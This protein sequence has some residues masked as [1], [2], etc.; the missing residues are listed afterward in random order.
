MINKKTS[1]DLKKIYNEETY[2]KGKENFHTFD[3][4][5]IYETIYKFIGKDN[6]IVSGKSVLDLGCG[7]GSF[8]CNYL[9]SA[10]FIRGIDFSEEAIKKAKQNSYIPIVRFDCISFE[11]YLKIKIIEPVDVV[12]SLD[13]IEHCVNPEIIF[14]VAQ[15]ALMPNGVLIIDHPCF[16][17][18]RGALWKALE[19]FMEAEMTCTDLHTLFF[20]DIYDMTKKYGFE[21]QEWKT[22]R[23]NQANGENLLYDFNKRLR[24]AIGPLLN[25]ENDPKINHFIKY[26]KIMVEN[27][28]FPNN[29]KNGAQLLYK[30]IKK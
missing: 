7:D 16:N 26:L 28:A 1:K 14:Q 11:D 23:H 12:F 27:G 9:H 21:I 8:I 15:R 19:I 6:G 24:K 10:D 18:V 22:F 5:D 30:I 13:A 3:P 17:N 20:S 25:G 2:K 29:A 4:E